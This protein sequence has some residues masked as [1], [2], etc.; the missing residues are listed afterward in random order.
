MKKE[1][2]KNTLASAIADLNSIYGEQTVNKF[3]DK[4]AVDMQRIS[5]G[6][7]GMNHISG[8]GLPRG[9][10]VEYFGW[11]STA[12]TTQALHD[13]VEHQKAGLNCAF[14]DYEQA[15]DQ[16]YAKSLGVDVDE[17]IYVAPDYAE[18]GLEIAEKLVDTGEVGLIVID[19]VA[20]M[21]PIS[22]I[23]GNMG[24]SKM[25]VHARLMSQALRKLMSK[26]KK[27]LTTIIFINQFREKIGVMY[28]DN[29]TT[30]GGNALKFY[31]FIRNEFR[32]KMGKTDSLEK[33]ITV[34]NKKNKVGIP[35]RQATFQV[36]FGTGF[37][38]Y[39]DLVVFAEKYGVI[40]RSGAWYN[41]GD[42]KLGQGKANVVS[43]LKD[44]VELFE[45]IEK[46]TLKRINDE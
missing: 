11:E 38:K 43:L 23:E 24:D 7:L 40:N 44:N 34:V 28:G 4:K 19:S 10:I 8:G 12:K 22:E 30:T 3:K 26:T 18:Q 37:D 9:V 1:N 33:E 21:T 39:D 16:R 45:E 36:V 27:N 13:I 42:V 5:Q 25:G 15:F 32:A 6:T 41:Y 35:H 2:Q 17:L 46:E 20:A 29:R 31:A 14:I